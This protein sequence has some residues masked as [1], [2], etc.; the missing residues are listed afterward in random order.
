MS[1]L[2]LPNFT[3]EKNA[4]LQF[5]QIIGKNKVVGIVYGEK[6]WEASKDKVLAGCQRASLTIAFSMC[7]G[8]EATFENIDRIIKNSKEKAISCLIGVGGGKCLDTVKAAA[9]QLDLPVYTVATIASTCAAATS[10]SILY[11][12]DGSFREIMSL[13]FPARHIFIDPKI[14]ADAP[15]KY[16]W[17]GIGD[18]MAKHV[19]SVF[20]AKNDQLDFAS[21]LGI[22]IGE[23]C[24]YPLL[25]DGKKALEEYDEGNI[26]D[27]FMRTILNILITTACVSLSVNAAY[28]SAVAHALFYGL[29]LR[30]HIE[31]TH[32]HG[33]VVS[34]GTLVQL[35]VDKQY[36]L[37]KQV[38]K[39]NKSIGLPVKL[40]DLELAIDDDLG[41]ILEATERN[42]ELEHVP[43]T[44]SKEMIYQAMKALE[45]YEEDII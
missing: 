25:R 6:A 40:A 45:T 31:Q 3:A 28:N 37:L 8:H 35:M 21:E 2:C 15:R 14:I 16:L 36:D 9:D 13:R 44:I 33:E 19:E 27:A 17:A 4:C 43:Y 20:S 18:T 26:Q 29:T 7:Y 24:F 1:T 34:Y 23:N 10:I 32:L 38:Y 22:K 12:E 11:N 30:K 5:K 42:K 41:D 39:F